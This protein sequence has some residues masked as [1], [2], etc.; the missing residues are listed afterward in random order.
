[1]ARV[2]HGV[3]SRARRGKA[4]KAA[5]GFVGGRRKLNRTI[6]ETLKRSMF[7]AYRDR[8]VRKRDF[9]S[10][11]IAR[12]NAAARGCGLSYSQFISG[13]QKSGVELDRKVLAQIALDEPKTFERL[14]KD[15]AKALGK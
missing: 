9:R 6:Q 7:F 15:A 13:L 11:W 3:A 4:R 14:A 2:R 12:I 10:L 1:M 8:K 5:K